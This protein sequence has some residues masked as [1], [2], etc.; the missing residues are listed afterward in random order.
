MTR[1]LL[2]AALA[3]LA[4][5]PL[6]GC[7]VFSHP[8][9]DLTIA[10][11]ANNTSLN[12][13]IRTAVY[14]RVDANTAELYFSDLPEERFLEPGARLGDVPG[15]VL[16][17]H[18]FLTPS[19]GSTPID[20]TACNVTLKQVVFAPAAPSTSATA[21]R[22][23]PAVGVYGGGGFFFP[24]GTL[25]TGVFGG[26]IRDG[27]F[28]LIESSPGFID[29]LGPSS[30]TGKLLASRDDV[31]ADAMDRRMRELLRAGRLAPPTNPEDTVNPNG[32]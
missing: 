22:S 8:G 28:R 24:S 7:R 9:G 5:F 32:E 25:G 14:K 21:Q 16:H 13:A 31:L 30:V 15:I 12:P 4:L 11:I 10:S 19:A 17:I 23:L 3:A 6:P 2:F 18:Y 1:S 29:A 27:T 26:S 20:D